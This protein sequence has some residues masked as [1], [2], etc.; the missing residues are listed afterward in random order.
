[1][2]RG[3]VCNRCSGVLDRFSVGA[4]S[5]GCD[6]NPFQMVVESA[7]VFAGTVTVVKGVNMDASLCND[8]FWL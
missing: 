5:R 1:M 6:A 2:K 8:Q 7:V 3:Q 4:Y